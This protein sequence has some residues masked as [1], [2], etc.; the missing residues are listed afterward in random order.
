MDYS[1]VGKYVDTRNR[2]IVVEAIQWIGKNEVDI[3][4][5]LEGTKCQSSRDIDICGKFFEI[6]FDNGGC[7]PGTI[8]LKTEIGNPNVKPN[9]FIIKLSD[10]M[11][12]SADLHHFELHYEKI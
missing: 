6:K 3:Y 5:F 12:T 7:M 9:N 1:K 10:G 2:H 8:L 4:N 11:F